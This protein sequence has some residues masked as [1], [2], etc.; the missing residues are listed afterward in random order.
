MHS[1][2]QLYKGGP[3]SGMFL[4]ITSEKPQ[5]LPIPG[6]KYTFGQLEMAQ[7]LGDLESLG[8]LGKPALRL[9][10]TEGVSEG[11]AALQRATERVFS[12]SRATI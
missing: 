7:A 1:I 9:H 12:A 4:M 2:G 6:A 10:F 5:D 11:L 8:R 3:V